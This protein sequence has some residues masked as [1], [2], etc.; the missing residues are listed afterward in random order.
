MA[1]I[2]PARA[3]GLETTMGQ[4]A[5]GQ[6]ANLTLVDPDFKVQGTVSGGELL[7]LNA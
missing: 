4:L 5:A 1:T 7:L 3:I 2:N 6:F